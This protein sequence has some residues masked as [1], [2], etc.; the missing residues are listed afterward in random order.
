MSRLS[1][2]GHALYEGKVSINF[3]GR[4]YLWYSISA[5]IVLVAVLG[6]TVKQLNMGIEFEGGVEYRVAMPAGQADEQA[7][8]KIR[9]AVVR[10]DF[11]AASAPIVNTSGNDGIRIQTEP[12]SNDDATTVSEAIQKAAGVP[13]DSVSSSSIGPSKQSFATSKPTASEASS[14][15]ARASGNSDAI[16]CPMPTSCEPWPG[17]Q[18]AIFMR[19]A[20]CSRWCKRSPR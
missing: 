13:Q 17:K 6:L 14:K 2:I 12:L 1:R 4:R 19:P 3:V 9:D 11:D 16:A 18:K 10:T 5:L 15:T 7:V 8:E 20:R